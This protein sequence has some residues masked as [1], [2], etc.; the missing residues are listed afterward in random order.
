[1]RASHINMAGPFAL[2][3]RE[4]VDMIRVLPVLALLWAMILGSSG[5]GGPTGKGIHKDQDR[6][7]PEKKPS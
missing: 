4:Y 7:L 6:P 2:F 1:M 3:W 5:C